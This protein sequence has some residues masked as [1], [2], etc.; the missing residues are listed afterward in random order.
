LF[1]GTQSN[2]LSVGENH[3]QPNRSSCFPFWAERYE[4]SLKVS[5]DNQS[6]SYSTALGLQKDPFPLEPDPLFYYAFDSFEERVA[7]LNRQVQG[8]DF[9]VLVIGEW[10]IGK[11]T[12]LNRFLASTRSQLKPARIQL[13]PGDT[14][15]PD[16]ETKSRVDYPA[17]ILQDSGDP[18]V[19]M[20]DAHELS[21]GELH[22]L[23]QK[24]TTPGTSR[25]IKRWVLFGESMLMSSVTAL[26]D[27]LS[28]D[29]AVNKIYM[30]AVAREET[31]GYLQHRLMLAGY[32]GKDLFDASVVKKIHKLSGGLP[33]HMNAYTDQ[34]LKKTYAHPT[35]YRRLIRGLTASPIRTVGWTTAAIAVI[36]LAAAVWLLPS[37]KAQ[38]PQPVMKKISTKT[39]RAKIPAAPESEK[40]AATIA[41]AQKTI[42]EP[43]TATEEKIQ[44]LPDASSP[45]PIA[46]L[47]ESEVPE[48]E[49]QSE[50][51][52]PTSE[53][54]IQPLPDVSPPQAIAEPEKAEI[55]KLES[56]S[57]EVKPE[58]TK[59][60]FKAPEIHREKWLL[61]HSSS[62]YTIQI[63][64]VRNEQTLLNFVKKHRL[65][66]QPGEIAYYRTT[67][68]GEV[69]YPLLYGVYATKAEALSGMGEL[70]ASIQQSTPWVRKLSAVQAA[71]RKQ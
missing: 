64:G 39:F 15:V 53:A 7:T 23:L 3:H 17:F 31:A 68:R 62:F 35:W 52:Q 69:W 12:L 58:E 37:W 59:E 19:I 44:P 10:G 30:P 40:P 11:T 57:V 55:G 51:K 70:P 26:A 50:E 66:E 34:W 61:S 45:Q 32:G 6:L 8:S 9:I 18:I 5:R 65:R 60:K 47:N 21:E 16:S 22:Y 27:V 13:S 42:G 1:V 20:D 29:I 56:P 24:A 54:K 46:V 33:G 14:T 43:P 71:I 41:T 67:Y 38:T 48:S 2:G 63:L 4:S 25:K 36:L 49:S 28:G